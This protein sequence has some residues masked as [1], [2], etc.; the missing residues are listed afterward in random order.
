MENFQSTILQIICNVGTAR[1]AYIEAI[2]AARAGKF[3]E[4]EALMEEGKETFVLGHEAHACLLEQEASG[5]PV[6]VQLLLIHAEDQLM[7]AEDF[8]ILAEELI[9]NYKMIHSLTGK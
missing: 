3:E 7:S 4:A 6:E 9:E 5:K 8:S 1:S 2:K